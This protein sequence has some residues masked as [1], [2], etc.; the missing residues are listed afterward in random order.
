MGVDVVDVLGRRCRRRRAPSAIARAA[1]RA[2]R[3][4]RGQVVGVGRSRRSRARRRGSS[5][6][7]PRACSASS[8]T[9]TPAPSPITKPSR[10]ASNGREMP[11]SRQRVQRG[12]RGAWRAASAPPREPPVTT[13]SASP[14]WIMP[15]RRADRVRARR[16]GG[17][18]AVGLAAQ[19]VAH[20]TARRRRRC[21]SSAAPTAARPS[22]APCVA[23]HVVAAPRACRCRRCRC[24]S[25]SRPGRRRTAARRPSRPRRAPRRAADER[26]LG[27]AVGAARLLDARGARSGSNSVAAPSPSS[28]PDSP[29]ASSARAASGRRRPSGVTAPTPVMTTARRHAARLD[30]QVDGVADGLDAFRRRRP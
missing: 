27:E 9:S 2:A 16:A 30:H 3:L 19:A 21:P 13:A 18:D 10:R 26:E 12:E 5:R 22:S 24:R 25:R 6:R 20:A 1:P 29:G 23:Q 17:D 8:S 4:G 11:V 28:I 7:A 15:R 14:D